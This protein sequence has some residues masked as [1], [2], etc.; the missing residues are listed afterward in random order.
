MEGDGVS[1]MP[2]LVLIVF[3]GR[4]CTTDGEVY[5]MGGAFQAAMKGMK[6]VRVNEWM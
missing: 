3:P 6:G 4:G 1:Y 5:F 2:Y